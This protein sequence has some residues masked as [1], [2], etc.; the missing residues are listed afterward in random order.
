MDMARNDDTAVD[1]IDASINN[2]RSATLDTLR[3]LR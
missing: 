2:L 3:S 1:R